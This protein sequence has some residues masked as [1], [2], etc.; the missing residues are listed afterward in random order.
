MTQAKKKPVN[1]IIV[2][3]QCFARYTGAMAKEFPECTP[4]FMSHMLT[5]LKAC[6]EVEDPAWCLYDEMYRKKIAS[7]S[8]KRWSGMDVQQVY[9]EV[10]VGHPW[11]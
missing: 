2:W 11:K 8:V 5:V 7:T 6:G 1:S 3:T 10:C 9:Q 4:D